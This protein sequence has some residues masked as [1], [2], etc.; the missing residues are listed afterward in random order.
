MGLIIVLFTLIQ[1]A[2]LGLPEH[3]PKLMSTTLVSVVMSLLMLISLNFNASTIL[4]IVILILTHGLAEHAFPAGSIH[5]LRPIALLDCLILMVLF[6]IIP[7]V[8]LSARPW[9]LE[10]SPLELKYIGLVLGALLL[11]RE[12]QWLQKAAL[13]TSRE[14]Q[15]WFSGIT[16][17][18]L[19]YAGLVVGMPYWW[20][21]GILLTKGIFI[22][23]R[24]SV[25]IWL[26]SL[27][28]ALMTLLVFDLIHR[29]L[30]G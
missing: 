26:S 16:E 8:D 14:V 29:A 10:L 19:M 3:Q 24:T 15:P 9:V 27:G 23:A 2:R 7:W 18:G 5:R 12:A 25:A 13:G 28:S 21:L 1:L 22:S 30:A 11:S 17:R 4:F 6:Q 20:L